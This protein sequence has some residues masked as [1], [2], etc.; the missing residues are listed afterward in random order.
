[1]GFL[2]SS[3][4]DPPFPEQVKEKLSSIIVQ[5]N[6]EDYVNIPWHKLVYS[7]LG[8]QKEST[9]QSN[10]DTTPWIQKVESLLSTLPLK[11]IS[12]T[13]SS[14]ALLELLPKKSSKG[15]AL[16]HLKEMYPDR[17]IICV[18]DFLNDLDMLLAADLPACP[19]NAL[20]E[21]KRISKIHLCHHSEGCIADLIYRLD[22]NPATMINF[23]EEKNGKSKKG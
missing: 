19:D 17:I 21:I 18:G 11:S 23:S 8:D 2:C 13:R 7:S 6:L 10:H 5:G 14:N 22:Q 12:V 3:D 4:Q 15:Q 16:R 20:E 1:L 9:P